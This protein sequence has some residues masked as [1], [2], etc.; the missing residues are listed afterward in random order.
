MLTKREAA[1]QVLREIKNQN[2][3]K[4]CLNTKEEGDSAPDSPIKAYDKIFQEPRNKFVIKCQEDG[5]PFATKFSPNG[6]LLAM[7]DSNSNLGIYDTIY[8]YSEHSFTKSENNLP[9]ITSLSWK[10]SACLKLS[11]RLVGACV[12]GSVVVWEQPSE[13]TIQ[14]VMLNDKNQYQTIDHSCNGSHIV[15]GGKLPQ[16]EIYDDLTLKQ[17]NCFELLEGHNNRIFS[18]KFSTKNPNFIYTGSWDRSVKFW[19]LRQSKMTMQIHAPQI[20]GES[21]DLKKDDYTMVIGSGEIGQGIQFWDI[22]Q[23]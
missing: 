3:D 13:K 1:R 5:N 14:K 9:L 2:R 6:G 11:Q 4:N 8:G 18:A 22:R 23:L 17:I 21:I 16:V 10:K 7:A 20:C 15:V 19:D 12:D